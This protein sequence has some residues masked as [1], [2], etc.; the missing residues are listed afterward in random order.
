MVISQFVCEGCG[1]IVG[2]MPMCY[3]C[4]EELQKTQE[5]M[6]EKSALIKPSAES[7]QLLPASPKPSQ[8]SRERHDA[9]FLERGI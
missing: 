7:Q 9:G 6:F 4:I 8:P 5:W 2:C 1:K 3:D